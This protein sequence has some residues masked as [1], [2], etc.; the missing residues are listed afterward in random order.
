MTYRNICLIKTLLLPLVCGAALA[1]DTLVLPAPV[2]DRNAEAPVTYRMANQITGKGTLAIHWTD[3]LGRVVDE[4]K[5]PV[6]LTDENEF[7]FSIDLRRAVAMKNTLRVHLSFDGK[8]QKGRPLPKEEDTEID[9]VARP[10]GPKWRD[11]AIIMW[12]QYPPQLLPGLEKIGINGGQYSGR[13]PSL[14]ENFID[15]NM[16]WYSEGIGTD[17]YS[18][19]HEWRPDRSYGWALTQAEQLYKRD[20]S[21][22]EALKRHPSFWDPV[23]RARIHD[24]LVADARRNSPYRPFFYSLGDE[25]GIAELAAFWDFDFS[26][27]SLVPM[28]RWLLKQYGTLASLNREWGSDFSS[29]DLVTPMTTPEAMKQKDDNFASWADFKEWMDISFADALRMGTDAVHE[30]DPAAYV[31]VGGGQMPGWGG[32]DYAR[33]T[34]A[35]TA[36]EPY[37]IGANIEIIRSLNPQMPMLTTGFAGSDWEK[38]RVWY[39]LL[40][41]NRGLIIWDDKHEY[42]DKQG[43]PGQRGQEAAG[44]YNE[45]RDGVAAQVINS[46]PVTDAI[47]IHYSQASMRTEWM[48]AR[49]PNGD[50][51]MNRSP[52]TER[53]DNDFM[54][55]RESWCKLI[56]DEGLQYNFVAYN[57]LAR[58]EL[59]KH[60]YRVLVLPRSSS[61][62]KGEDDAIREFISQGGIVIADGEPGV[63]NEHSRRLPA[64]PLADLFGGAHSDAISIRQFGKG[65]AISIKTNTLDYLQDRLRRKEGPV[66]ELV[67]KLLRSNGIHPLFAVTDASGR[68][69]AGV[70]THVFRNGGTWLVTLLSNPQQ[71]VNELGPPDFRSNQ[72]FE[73]PVAVTLT[74]P[75]EMYLYDVRGNKAL[76]EKRTL[77]LTV[78]PYE[79]VILTA[80]AAPLPPLRVSAPDE[81]QLGSS[82]QI[83]ID[84]PQTPAALHVFHVDVVDPQGQ[85]VLNYSGNVLAK[86]GRAMKVIPLAY[87]D[88]SGSWN[89]HVHDLLSGQTA[90]RKLTVK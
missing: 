62:S 12:Q 49:R 47:A 18:P 43:Q 72:R 4:R 78:N 17:F 48:L 35:L 85:S 70:E 15:K 13:N 22:K 77:S 65:R 52:K 55:L 5:L 74:L 37:D 25:T 40:H 20:P 73:S 83:S 7:Q 3:S 10:P 76:G 19:Y 89:I 75:E 44:Y 1:A 82:A 90:I 42:V 88:P 6:E 57:D 58:G 71:R 14:P 60:G 64:S 61:L 28:R 51:W 32:Y 56:E 27:E 79:P 84:C 21:S 81:A 30:V 46:E 69:V 31:G 41:G 8:D 67:G 53:T 33:I 24:R 68:P 63:F 39:E 23:W 80:T 36:I 54:R 86:D 50:A 9:F 59:L 34:K 87:N 45:L 38:H 66:Q 11:Y 26:D 16:R 2:L 29:W